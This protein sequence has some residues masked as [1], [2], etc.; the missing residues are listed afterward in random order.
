MS[1]TVLSG[2]DKDIANFYAPKFLEGLKYGENQVN[3]WFPG[4]GKTVIINDIL[5]DKNLLKDI[6]G[7]SSS[8]LEIIQYS[9]SNTLNPTAE[10]ILIEIA[11]KLKVEISAD[12]DNII[13]DI[14]N[15]CKDIVDKKDKIFVFVGT[16]YEDME[17]QEFKKLLVS[18]SRIVSENRRCFF[19]ILNIVDREILQKIVS[20]KPSA[21]AI[22]TRVKT[23]PLI[24]GKLLESY[25]RQRFKEYNKI[26]SQSDINMISSKTGGIL[27]LT[28]ELIR[29]FPNEGQLNERLLSIWG[30]LSVKYREL[31]LNNI[32]NQEGDLFEIGATNLS[33]FKSK[34]EFLESDP[35]K[36]MLNQLNET[37]LGLYRLFKSKKGNLITRD[38]IAQV[39]WGKKYE[40]RYSDWAIDQ[41]MSRFR[42]KIQK[43]YLPK[44]TVKTIK[45]EGY[46]WKY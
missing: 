38:Q 12:K 1:K 39:I 44:E 17:L 22:I 14:I 7:K 36:S 46:K 32:G 35:E 3:I 37:E 40:E 19:S 20:E 34:I 28:R 16:K 15:H 5:S 27:F 26:V 42:K 13:L 41:T 10:S 9:C 24:S 23:M 11:K 45:G 18:I 6:L 4:S 8:R 29:N 43:Y 30:K 31:L 25:I 21:H 33:I 2:I